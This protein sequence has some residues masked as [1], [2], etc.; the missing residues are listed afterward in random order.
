MNKKQIYIGLGVLAVVAGIYLYRKSKKTPL[1][2][3]PAIVPPAKTADTSTEEDKSNFKDGDII[4]NECY[5]NGAFGKDCCA[6]LGINT[7][8]NL[9]AVNPNRRR[10]TQR[11]LFN[12]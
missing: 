9:Y 12:I 4:G 1:P 6:K 5:C 11:G 3:I 7:N 8:A 10:Y 2:K